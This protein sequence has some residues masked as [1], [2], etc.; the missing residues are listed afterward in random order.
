MNKISKINFMGISVSAAALLA[1][2]ALIIGCGPA[3]AVKPALIPTANNVNNPVNPGVIAQNAQGLND[4]SSF[5]AQQ[6]AQIN[7][8]LGTYTGS[9]LAYD[10]NGNTTNQNYTLTLTKGTSPSVPGKTFVQAN[11]S[12]GTMSFTSIMQTTYG[13]PVSGATG[14]NY[15]FASLEQTVYVSA[16]DGTTPIVLLVSLTMNAS[17]QFDPASS[18]NNNGNLGPIRIVDGVSLNDVVDFNYDF[19]RH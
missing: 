2:S 11:F 14:P 12:A 15:V 13:A 17:N 19:Q 8:L 5:S 1:S 3:P 9:F 6:Q 16:I 10:D 4:F 7:A 18:A